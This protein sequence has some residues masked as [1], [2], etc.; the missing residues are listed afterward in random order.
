LVSQGLF[1][2]VASTTDEVAIKDHLSCLRRVGSNSAN[3]Y[4][5]IYTG[6]HITF[7]EAK[8][9]NSWHHLREYDKWETGCPYKK[10][11]PSEKEPDASNDILFQQSAFT[12]FAIAKDIKD[13]RNVISIEPSIDARSLLDDV[14]AESFWSLCDDEEGRGTGERHVLA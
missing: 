9:S 3:P 8:D 5:N 1:V 14:L 6:F 12:I 11:D 10:R 4:N 13:Q 2:P 7:Y